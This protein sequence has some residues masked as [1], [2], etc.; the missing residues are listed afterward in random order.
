MSKLIFNNMHYTINL[1]SFGTVGIEFSID[2]AIGMKATMH[3]DDL[4]KYKWTS[5][6]RVHPVAA[7]Y[8]AFSTLAH[9]CYEKLCFVL[10]RQ[11]NPSARMKFINSWI[12]DAEFKIGRNALSLVSGPDHFRGLK[13]KFVGATTKAVVP[14]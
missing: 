9:E 4:Q 14:Q 13:K 2:H 1:S 11:D 12:E 3:L 10:E 5:F 6:S 8:V 7:V